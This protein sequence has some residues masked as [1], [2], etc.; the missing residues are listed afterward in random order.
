MKTVT[1]Y[2]LLFAAT[3]GLIA[4]D[5]ATTTETGAPKGDAFLQILNGV[6]P[7]PISLAWEG[8]PV[9]EQIVPGT[10]ISAMPVKAGEIALKV[11][12]DQTK[13]EKLFKLRV[14]HNTSNTLYI[15]GDFAPLTRPADADVKLPADYNVT[16]ALLKNE[17]PNGTKV[18]VK[19]INGLSDK[20]LTVSEARTHL[21]VGPGEVGIMKDLPPELILKATADTGS[22]TLYLAQSQDPVNLAVIFYEKDGRLAFRATT[23]EFR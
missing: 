17:K 19:I 16:A 20:S 18:D 9:Y 15:I 7:R 23:E 4:Q 13:A 22:T 2:A 3:T 11:K 21:T 6:A 12:D 14:D 8:G 5:T 10:R 1:R